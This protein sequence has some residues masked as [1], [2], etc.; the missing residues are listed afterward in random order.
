MLRATGFDAFV[1]EHS[2]QEHLALAMPIEPGLRADVLEVLD[3]CWANYY[4]V[5]ELCDLARGVAMLLY[6]LG[7]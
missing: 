6:R 3:A 4:S 2:L 5:G 7:E 1:L